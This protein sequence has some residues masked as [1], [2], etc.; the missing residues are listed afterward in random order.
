MTGSAAS[1]YA[2]GG[3]VGIVILGAV[4]LVV[5][6]RHEARHAKRSL[7]SVESGQV[8]RSPW[9]AGP[10]RRLTCRCRFPPRVSAAG[11]VDRFYGACEAGVKTP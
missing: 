3:D 6:G 1:L 5:A 2:V 10:C 7:W 8:Q 11:S 4:C 9:T